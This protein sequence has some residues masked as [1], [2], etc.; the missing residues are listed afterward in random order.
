MNKRFLKAQ[1]LFS[2]YQIDALLVTNDIDVRYLSQYPAASESWLLVTP[3][4]AFYLTD[5]RYFLEV[6]KALKGIQPIQ[7]QGT[8]FNTLF[9]IASQEKVARIG[10]NENQWT[11]ARY[12][13][14]KKFCPKDG[15]LVEANALVESLREIKEPAELAI[16]RQGLVI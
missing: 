7:Y 4:K 16:I 5:F 15:K 10:I 12:K 8:I 11:V 13:Q 3:K 6:K 1:S 9:D 14:L 2:Q